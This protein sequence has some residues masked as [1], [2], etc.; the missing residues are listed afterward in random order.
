MGGVVSGFFGANTPSQ[1]N[2]QVWQPQYT[3]QADTQAYNSISN[4]NNNNPYTQLQPQY[5]SVL[6]A[7][8]NNPHSSGAQTAANTAGQQ[9]ATTGQQGAASSTALN[10]ASNSLL[11]YMSTVMNTAMDPQSALYNQAKQNVADQANV[12]NAQNGLNG[13]PYGAGVANQAQTNFGIDWNAAKLNNQVTGLN[14]AGTALNN[15]SS[16]MTSAQNLGQS[17]ASATNASGA[18]PLA[19]YNTNLANLQSGLNNYSTAMTAGNQ[20]TQTAVDDLLN[21]MGLGAQQSDQQA[22]NNQTA[23]NDAVSAANTENQGLSSLV[24]SVLGGGASLVSGGSSSSGNNISGNSGST[25][26][27]GTGTA[28][29]AQNAATLASFVVGL[30]A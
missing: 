17:A 12:S 3:S 15:A 29:A 1:P 24:N 16:G 18:V 4:I 9:Y 14:A 22:Q 19:A 20:N 25:N 10:T 5:Q 28:T 27:S 23:Y 11:P 30:F 7:T 2:L 8:Q 26:T 21:Y 6:N 13:S